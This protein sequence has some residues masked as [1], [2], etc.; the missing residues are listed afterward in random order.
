MCDNKNKKLEIAMKDFKKTIKAYVNVGTAER[1]K[2]RGINDRSIQLN[3]DIT[4]ILEKNKRNR[5]T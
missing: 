3:K 2:Y 1:K 4:Q 5:R